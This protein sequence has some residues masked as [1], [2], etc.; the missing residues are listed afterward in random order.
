MNTV[1]DNLAAC[2]IQ[3]SALAFG[4]ETGPSTI[5]GLTEDWNGVSWTE[6]ADTSQSAGRRGSAGT[7]S[8]ALAIGGRNATTNISATEEWSG[9]ST[10][11]KT[12]STD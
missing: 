5:V 1:R 9:S 10:L 6:V 4:G 8:N 12:I 11:T 3:T 2:G 7:T